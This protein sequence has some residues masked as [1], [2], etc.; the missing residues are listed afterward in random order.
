ME[1]CFTIS[2]IEIKH[3]FPFKIK[4]PMMFQRGR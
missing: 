1:D 2:D 3:K 4:N